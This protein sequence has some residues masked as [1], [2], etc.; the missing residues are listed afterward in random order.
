M[1]LE[2]AHAQLLGAIDGAGGFRDRNSRNNG[3]V[4]SEA[5]DSKR[6]GSSE[7]HRNTIETAAVPV[8]RAPSAVRCP[9]A[10]IGCDRR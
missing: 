10:G 7:T 9:R 4:P 6:L 8:A 5:G 3:A 2:V 1:V